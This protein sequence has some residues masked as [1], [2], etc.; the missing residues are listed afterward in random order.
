MAMEVVDLLEPV[1]I[2]Q[3]QRE[4]AAVPLGMRGRAVKGFL[5]H[6]A[7]RQAGEAVGSRQ[8]LEL[9]LL[10]ALDADVADGVDEVR[11]IRPPGRMPARR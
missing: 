6:V 7:V 10:L 3:D 11:L 8:P 1:E 4:R 5:K 9:L 2:E